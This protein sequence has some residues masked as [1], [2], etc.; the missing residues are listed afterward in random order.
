MPRVK[1]AQ[2]NFRLSH[3]AVAALA[4]L[5]AMT[6]SSETAIVEQALIHYSRWA[7]SEIDRE[8][9]EVALMGMPPLADDDPH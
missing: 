3:Q 2:K 7:L 8:R 1:S 9:L 5:A 6:G 4:K